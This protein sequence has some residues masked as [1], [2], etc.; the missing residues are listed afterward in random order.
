VEEGSHDVLLAKGGLY[1]Q[2]WKRQSG[3]FLPSR[4]AAE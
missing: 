2:L 3:G 4:L 1:A